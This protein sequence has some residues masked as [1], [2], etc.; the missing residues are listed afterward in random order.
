ML[1]FMPGAVLLLCSFAGLFWVYHMGL[2]I[3]DVQTSQDL[4]MF[5]LGLRLE[6]ERA[7]TNQINGHVSKLE[8]GLANATVKVERVER[9]LIANENTNGTILARLAAIEKSLKAAAPTPVAV[10]QAIDDT[11]MDRPSQAISYQFD[12]MIPLVPTAVIH[13]TRDK[14]D[15]W[16]IPR[17][18]GVTSLRVIPYAMAGDGVVIHCLDDGRDY[19]LGAD[20]RW[21]AFWNVLAR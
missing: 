15:Y 10:P 7:T 2:G 9:Q 13:R 8:E 12:P 1:Q 4:S 6:T 19:I 16:L 17:D 18:N 3:R 14:P 5:T 20:G 21:K 11:R